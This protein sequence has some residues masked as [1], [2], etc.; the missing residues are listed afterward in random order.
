MVDRNERQPSSPGQ[1]LRGRDPDEQC[2]DETRPLRHGDAVDVVELGTGL[3][4]RLPERRQQE[5][6]MMPG[7]NLRY[8]AA[9]AGVQLGLRGDDVREE[10]PL[11]RDKRGGGLVAGGLD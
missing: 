2:P 11:V 5:L 3:V 4:E 6:E 1:G 7:R 10:L 9:V 8:H